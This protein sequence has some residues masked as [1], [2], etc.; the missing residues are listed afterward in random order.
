MSEQ[1]E[2]LNVAE[3]HSARS[4]LTAN[5]YGSQYS[6]RGLGVQTVYSTREP[7]SLPRGV[8]TTQQ[9]KRRGSLLA[10][11][12][13]K[14]HCQGGEPQEVRDSGVEKQTQGSSLYS[15]LVQSRFLAE[16]V[17]AKHCQ[18]EEP[19]EV[20]GRNME[21][22]TQGSSLYSTIVQ[23]RSLAEAGAARTSVKLVKFQRLTTSQ[24]R[25]ESRLNVVKSL[26]SQICPLDWMKHKTKNLMSFLR[27]VP[28]MAQSNRTSRTGSRGAQDVQLRGYH[29]GESNRLH[30]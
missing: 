23:S 7:D 20:T 2:K 13:S 17:S 26:Q 14:R 29:H 27:T 8:S 10:V 19:R 16:A 9:V 3:Q 25:L 28:Q 4:R 12:H 21:T 1:Q 5:N 24:G 15:R 6:G 18:G 22:L 11:L 30:P